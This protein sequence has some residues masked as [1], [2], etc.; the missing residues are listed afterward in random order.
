MRGKPT[1]CLSETGSIV[2]AAPVSSTAPFF[3]MPEASTVCMCAY[4]SMFLCCQIPA[5]APDSAIVNSVAKNVVAQ[6]PL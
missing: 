4:S 3:S 5:L 1:V 2:S 6:V